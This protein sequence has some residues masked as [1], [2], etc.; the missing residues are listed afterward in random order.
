MMN[1]PD[2]TPQADDILFLDLGPVFEQWEAD[3]GCT[4]VLGSNP[5]KL[6]MRQDVKWHS[7]RGKQYFKEHLDI[8]S[9]E[10][11]HYAES[12]AGKYGWEF[13]APSPDTLLG[14]FLTR[15]SPMTR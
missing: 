14:S 8:T 4:F 10:L 9:R 3:F 7:L 12:L 15:E 1:P 6:K 5:L 13:G 11:F 2:L